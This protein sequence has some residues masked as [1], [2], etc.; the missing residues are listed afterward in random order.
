MAEFTQTSFK[1]I[2]LVNG[3]A[4]I[5]SYAQPPMD[6]EA[7]QEIDKEKQQRRTTD[8]DFHGGGTL[9]QPAYQIRNVVAL[10]FSRA[11]AAL[12]EGS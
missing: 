3:T 7:E 12:G 10:W 8:N 4:P 6:W 2:A 5:Q 1:T 9:D 11:S